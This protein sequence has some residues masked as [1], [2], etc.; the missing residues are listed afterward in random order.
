MTYNLLDGT[1]VIEYGNMVSAP[2]C[3]KIL[4]DLGAEVI[5]IEDPE[6]G[7]RS[8]RREPFLNDI[9]GSERSGLFLYH[10]MNKLGITLNL[11]TATGKKIFA[12]L[13]R[14]ANIFV[15]NNLPQ[16]A[17]ALGITYSQVSEINPGIVMTS[18]TPFGQ[19]GPY[20]HYKGGE[21]IAAH[22]GGAGKVSTRET[23]LSDPPIK[24]PANQ[25]TTQ[26]G[27]AAAAGTLG[28]LYRQGLTGHGQYLDISEQDSVVQNMSVALLYLYYPKRIP[29]RSD[30][31]NIAP[32]HILPC[33]DGYINMAFIQEGQWKR[34]LEVMGKPEWGESELFQNPVSR[35]EY[36]DGLRPLIVEWTMQYNKTEIFQLCQDNRVPVSPLN[37]GKDLLESRQMAS[38]GF[39]VEVDHP[40]T[41]KLKYPGTP[42]HFGVA[43]REE[44]RPAP[45][46]G[47]HNEA[48]YCGRLGYSKRDLAK[49]KEAG[50][51]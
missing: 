29:S 20:R 28:A 39:I 44:P 43:P 23:E 37:T 30:R 45:L 15:E 46:L 49:L 1:R 18:L 8:R 47:Q 36:W 34:L 10:N 16:A 38:R 6:G 32:Y 21:L 4:G 27:L 19:T 12:D 3:A 24:M 7:D 22:T 35:A 48:I 14:D 2:F 26:A 25:Y 40:E 42:Y 17:E 11:R 13:L 41:G 33:K 5:K 50:I 31:M 9:P 51:I